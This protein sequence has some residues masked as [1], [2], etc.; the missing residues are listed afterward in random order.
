MLLCGSLLSDR[1]VLAHAAPSVTDSSSSS[2]VLARQVDLLERRNAELE[3]KLLGKSLILILLH[4][5]G[6]QSEVGK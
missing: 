5:P 2:A 1:S 3:Q 6:Q 4:L